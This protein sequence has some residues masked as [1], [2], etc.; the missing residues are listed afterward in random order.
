MYTNHCHRGVYPIAVDKYIN[1]YPDVYATHTTVV[2]GGNAYNLI[3][4]S[5][6]REKGFT[7]VNGNCLERSPLKASSC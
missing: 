3:S 4:H 5:S 2:Y 1:I 6:G 7:V